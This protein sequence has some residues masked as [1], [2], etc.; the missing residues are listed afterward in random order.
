[1]Y[2]VVYVIQQISG[3]NRL[4]NL[5]LQISLVSYVAIGPFQLR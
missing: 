3:I 2:V 5:V 4:S 1:M